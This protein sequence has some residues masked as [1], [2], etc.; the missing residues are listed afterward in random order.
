MSQQNGKPLSRVVKAL[1]EQIPGEQERATYREVAIRGRTPKQ[2]AADL[3]ISEARIQGMVER[4]RR[5]LSQMSLP[6]DLRALQTQ[7]LARLEHQWHEAMSAWYRSSNMEETIKSSWE[8]QKQQKAPP[9]DGKRKVERTTREPCG[10]VRYLEQARKIMAEYR[11]LSCEVALLQKKEKQDA[12]ELSAS[13]RDEKAAG[14]IT[15]VR[16]RTR[17]KEDS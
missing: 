16:E 14:A 11:A 8:D 6:V 17:K 13:E 1:H 12:N 10:D 5:W 2:L 9:K 7:H 4:V 3:K 15:E